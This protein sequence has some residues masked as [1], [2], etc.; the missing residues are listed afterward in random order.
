ML[1]G[2]VDQAEAMLRRLKALG[3]TIAL[4]DFG[5]GYSSFAYIQHFPIDTLKVD[6][7]FVRAMLTGKSAVAIVSAIIA[8]AHNLGMRVI[9]EGV[10]MESQRQQLVDLGCDELQGYLLGR[11]V[12]G[13]DFVAV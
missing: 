8:L 1:M 13:A 2:K 7:T 3:V 6:Q 4:D 9:A 5:T 12:P 11:P 10:E